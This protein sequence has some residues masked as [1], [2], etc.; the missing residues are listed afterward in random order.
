MKRTLG[1][2]VRLSA[3]YL[4]KHGVSDAGVE[5]EYLVSSVLSLGRT[6]M[7]LNREDAVGE[8]TLKILRGMIS[9]RAKG[10]P[11]SY[12]TGR[13]DFYGMEFLVDEHCLIPRRETEILVEE[14]IRAAEANYCAARPERHIRILDIGCGCGNIS[15]AVAK[16]V[17]R[18]LVSAVDLSYGAVLK[19][20]QN[21]LV[22]G[23]Y[24]KITAYR[25]DLFSPFENTAKFLGYFDIIVSNPPYISDGDIGLSREV[26]EYEPRG[27]LAGGR[28][29]LDFYRRI[30]PTAVFFLAGGGGL[31]FE[32]G[33]GQKDSVASLL[34][35]HGYD[36]IVSLRD[37]GGVDRVVTARLPS[38]AGCGK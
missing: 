29:G 1:E 6:A 5:A 32:V 27:A 9:E 11:S 13:R 20:C 19:T 26:A 24:T 2:I 18:A 28:D 10:K 38:G 25:G 16:N 3:E 17:E 30:I 23:V 12:L 14:V 35:E 36:D 37:Y 33:P 15:V 8:K 4:E 31:F 34:A 7:Y 22:N 21:A